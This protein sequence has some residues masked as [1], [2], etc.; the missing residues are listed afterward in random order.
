MKPQITL[1]K[2]LADPALLGDA[3]SGDSWA[4]WRILLIAAMGEPLNDSERATFKQLT[5]RERE[6]GQRV[7]ELEAVVGRRGGKSRA[8]SVLATYLTA[9]CDHPLSPGERGVLLLVAPDQRQ[10]KISL[11]YAAANFER[12]PILGQLVSA[13]NSDTIELKNGTNIEVR[14]ASFRRLRGPTY[15][16]IIAD[17]A[18][19]FYSD[20]SAANV[21][22]EILK[23]VRPGLATTGGPLIIASSP[24]A[25]RGE[26]WETY[27]RHFGADGD[28]LI[29]VAQGASRQ[30]NPSLPQSVIDRAMERD[31]AA[32]RAEYLA[33]FRTDIESFISVEAVRSCVNAGIRERPPVRQWKYIAFADPAGGS[34]GDSMTLCVSHR[35]GNTCIVDAL[36]EAKPP[37]SPEA[38][39]EE[40]S[41]LMKQ[42]RITRVVG[43]RFGGEFPR[44]AFRKCGINYEP[45][46]RTK[47]ELYIDL[48]PL[49]NSRAV[50]L[51]DHEKAILQLAWLERRTSRGGRRD[52]IDHAPAGHDDLANVIAGAIGLA[53][54]LRGNYQ[55]WR[56]QPRQLSAPIV[57]P[58]RQSDRDPLNP[59]TAWMTRR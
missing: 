31:E 22:S 19:Y 38:V 54:E 21:D 50:D 15:I 37:F 49:I 5:G 40:F 17:E 33:M 12:S 51:L 2:A 20:E 14:S 44:E 36:R 7:D 8:M 39:T 18:A 48:L 25:R 28:P 53:N 47:S 13:R 58:R 6:P 34:G 52:F 16:G 35:E 42:Y 59:N 27:R 4:T 10:A 3:L 30:F 46:E 29:L 57:L 45:S 24:Y 32:A 23:A 26:V 56:R 55:D 41:E 11:D 9:L 43:D 1:R